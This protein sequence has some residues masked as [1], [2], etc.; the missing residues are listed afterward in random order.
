MSGRYLE[1]ATGKP[2]LLHGDTAWSIIVQLTKEEA[3]EYLENRRRK[4]FNSIVVNLLEYYYANNPPKNVHGVGPFTTPG[5]FSTP[6]EAYFAHAD[7]ML[8]KA[9]EKGIL[10][11]LNPCY[12]GGASDGWW[13]EVEANGP[14]KCRNYGRYLGNRY[15]DYQ[16]II[17]VAGGDQTPPAGSPREKNFLEIL[18]GVKD[19]AP[20]HLWTAHWN[21]KIDA[22]DVEAFRPYMDL[23]GVYSYGTANGNIPSRMLK[24]YNRPDFKPTFLWESW[25]EGLTWSGRVEPLTVIRR[26]AYEANLCGATGQDFGSNHIWSFGART[27]SKH[28]EPDTDWRVGMEKPGSQ[29]MAYVKALFEA[30]AWHELVPDQ[31]HTVVTA[32]Y[33]TL[34]KGDYVSAARVG[35]GSLVIAYVPSTGTESRKITVNM[36]RLSGPVNARWYN[37]TGGT[38]RTIA[39]S[40]LANSGSREFATPGDNGTGTS[41]WVLLLELATSQFR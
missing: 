29:Q 38:Y 30:R 21:N 19:N 31:D 34:G 1:D 40:P 28:S 26:Q 8:S 25:Y 5:D 7:W 11:L 14:T 36:E 9:S 24:A 32:G 41:D 39:E 27:H 4:G 33:G 10:V 6:N 16:N 22:L 13:R 20:G 35:D 2:F 18:L 3:E 23:N 12:L 17:W 15:K 37:P